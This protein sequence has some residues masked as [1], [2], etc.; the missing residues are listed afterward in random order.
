[1]SGLNNAAI[2]NETYLLYCS[3]DPPG[4]LALTTLNIKA[5]TPMFKVPVTSVAVAGTYTS[6]YVEVMVQPVF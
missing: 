6:S 1:M 4:D 2:N 5:G 3:S